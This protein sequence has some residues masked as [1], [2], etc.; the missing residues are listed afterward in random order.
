MSCRG[1]KQLIVPITLQHPRQTAQ[2]ETEIKT[3]RITWV[4][5]RITISCIRVRMWIF[6]ALDLFSGRVI[7]LLEFINICMSQLFVLYW[8]LVE[9]HTD[10]TI[11]Q[12]FELRAFELLARAVKRFHLLVFRDLFLASATRLRIDHTKSK[13]P[14]PSTCYLIIRCMQIL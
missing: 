3:K 10:N 2:N 8:M 5:F 6:I 4:S 13:Q 12:P 1:R 9:K 14:P 11:K 7:D